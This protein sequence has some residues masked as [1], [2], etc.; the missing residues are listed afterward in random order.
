M[1]PQVQLSKVGR[2]RPSAWG[3]VQCTQQLPGGQWGKEMGG[4][5]C[6]SPSAVQALVTSGAAPGGGQRGG[7]L[8]PPSLVPRQL[9]PLDGAEKG[10]TLESVNAEAPGGVELQQPCQQGGS[11]AAEPFGQLELGVGLDS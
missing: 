6:P 3:S 5:S 2:Q 7:D 1:R 10:V 9:A 8:S 4:P 11:W